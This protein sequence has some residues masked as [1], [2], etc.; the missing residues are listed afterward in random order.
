MATPSKQKWSI[1]FSYS[2]EKVNSIGEATSHG[3]ET[4]WKLVEWFKSDEESKTI[5]Y[6]GKTLESDNFILANLDVAGYFRVNYDENNWN[7][8]VKQL[9]KKHREV[10]VRMKAQLINDAFDFSQATLVKA[11]LPLEITKFLE[12]EQDYLP[13]SAFFSRFKFYKD[14]LDTTRLFSDIETKMAF[15]VKPMFDFLG[16]VQNDVEHSWVQRLLRSRL[17]DFACEYGVDNCITEAKIHF[18]EWIKD[19]DYSK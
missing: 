12:T 13:W 8:I 7:N 19:T 2:I 5:N 9:D 10:P 4:I 3:V 18:N 15:L 17:V 1:P 14:M 16:F 11:D 6:N